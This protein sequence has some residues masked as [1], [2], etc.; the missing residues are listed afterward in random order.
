MVA[1]IFRFSSNANFWC[2]MASFMP[3]SMVLRTAGAILHPQ[4]APWEY[5]VNLTSEEVAM[6]SNRRGCVDTRSRRHPVEVRVH[7]PHA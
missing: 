7:R 6:G 5:W 3:L 1:S 2:S 4:P